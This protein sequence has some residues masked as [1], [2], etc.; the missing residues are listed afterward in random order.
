MPDAKYN[1]PDAANFNSWRRHLKLYSG[2]ENDEI[3]YKWEDVKAM[4]NGGTRKRVFTPSSSSSSTA[5]SL[6]SSSISSMS[7]S[8]GHFSGRSHN[9]PDGGSGGKKAKAT[10][11]MQ[12][13]PYLPKPPTFPNPFNPYNWLAAGQGKTPYP[14]MA[15]NSSQ[16]M[17]FGFPSQATA[18]KEAMAE[19]MKVPPLAPTSWMG[20]SATAGP[21]SLSSMDLFW[22]KAFSFPQAAAIGFRNS[23]YPSP[24]LPGATA[25]HSA[26]T[27]A[28]IDNPGHLSPPSEAAPCHSPPHNVPHNIMKSN[29]QRGEKIRDRMS[30]FK[31]VVPCSSSPSSSL[32]PPLNNHD[33]T[34]S[35]VHNDCQ[36]EDDG[37]DDSDSMCA[38]DLSTHKDIEESEEIDVE[39]DADERKKKYTEQSE[40]AELNDIV[41]KEE[42]S[43]CENERQQPSQ[44][45]FSEA[46][47]ACDEKTENGDIE[48]DTVRQVL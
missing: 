20:R 3:A 8:S 4:F 10:T 32:S 45:N 5:S 44:A 30:A 12:S 9:N 15:M 48:N 22:D 2:I 37:E 33:D 29:F 1:H 34:H 26:V 40:I 31:R 17:C 43:D 38:Q 6:N 28:I 25:A 39:E 35:L 47:D 23:G 14:F 21:F 11:P 16:S 42:N 13:N 7:H 27:A 18:N 24:A 41:D 36:R 46:D 19:R